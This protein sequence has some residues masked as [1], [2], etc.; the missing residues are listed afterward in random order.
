[1]RT[2]LGTKSLMT[3]INAV[4]NSAP[5]MPHRVY[6]QEDLDRLYPTLEVADAVDNED[7][8]EDPILDHGLKIAEDIMTKAVDH[9]RRRFQR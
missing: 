1:M 6:G 2:G 5:I 3:E 9:G 4:D 8:A 7:E